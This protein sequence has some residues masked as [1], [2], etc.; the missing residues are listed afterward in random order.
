MISEQANNSER[1]VSLIKSQIFQNQGNHITDRS[2]ITTGLPM[3]NQTMFKRV[4]S[5]SVF[6]QAETLNSISTRG[7]ESKE[8]TLEHTPN[9]N[10]LSRVN[11]DGNHFSIEQSL[12]NVLLEK[13]MQG[14]QNQ[15]QNLQ[16]P[17]AAT[18][19]TNHP[20]IRA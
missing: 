6:Q 7:A 15:S 18:A 2:E 5:F 1:E 16:L 17:T 11:T 14:S 3:M 12:D 10:N 20:S 19:M 4:A 13:K 9:T 8:K